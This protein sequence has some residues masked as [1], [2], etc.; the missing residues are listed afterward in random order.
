[1]L[2][3]VVRRALTV[4]AGPVVSLSAGAALAQ[5]P[6]VEPSAADLA[7]ATGRLGDAEAELYAASRRAPREPA[8]RG[9]L[10]L[11]LASR[12]R[13]KVGSVLLEEARQFGADPIAVGARL[14]HVY[15]WQGDWSK[16]VTLSGPAADDLRDMARWL[17]AHPGS[18]SGPD[19]SSMTLTPNELAGLGRITITVGGEVVPADIDPTVE[20]L[21]LP[22]TVGVMAAL[23]TFP[24]RGGGTAGVAYTVNIGAY[25]LTGVPARLSDGSGARVGLDVLSPLVPTFD[26]AA[27]RLTLRTHE[28]ASPRGEALPFLLSFPGVRVVAREGQ[29][30]APL[31]SAA[32]RAAVRGSKW[33]FDL[34]RGALLLER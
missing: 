30:P 19:S 29:A 25:T 1:M 5:P 28:P 16:V 3:A 2:S 23:R 33:T 18:V 4:A 8:A 15:R 24:I 26:A 13:L 9:A 10:G 20:G 21:V 14:A 32:G 17:A 22:S 6:R 27:R 31:E 12:G 11:F 34:R 7:I